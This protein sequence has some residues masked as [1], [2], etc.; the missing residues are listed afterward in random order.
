M[1]CAAFAALMTACGPSRAVKL[2]WD[3]PAVLPD[4][5]HI[6]VDGRVALDITPPPMDRRCDCL[7]VTF[8]VPRGRHTLRVEACNT[9]GRC[10]Q[11]AEVVVR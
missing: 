8:R 7:T 4:R 10:A 5:Y 3:V 2:G 9:S 11:S 1:L 6:S